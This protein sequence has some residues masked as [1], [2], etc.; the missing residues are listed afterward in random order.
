VTTLAQRLRVFIRRRR[1]TLAVL[2]TGGAAGIVIV[3]LAGRWNEFAT[4]A[5]GAPWWILTIAA[6]L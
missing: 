3:A 4:A 2:A 1:V 5:A 6:A